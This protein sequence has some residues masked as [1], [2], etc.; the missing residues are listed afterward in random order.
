[1]VAQWMRLDCESLPAS[2]GWS[3]LPV[4]VIRGG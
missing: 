3:K 2:C 1:M 4:C